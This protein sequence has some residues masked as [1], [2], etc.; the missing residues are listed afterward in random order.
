MNIGY[1]IVSVLLQY[2][3]G[4]LI[5]HVPEIRE[6]VSAGAGPAIRDAVEPFLAYIEDTGLHALQEAYTRTFDLGTETTLYMT[7]HL[8][9][10][11]AD[12]GMALSDLNRRYRASGYENFTS[13]LPDFLPL[14][15]EF[16]SVCDVRE[17][18]MLLARF[19]DGFSKLAVR[20]K[21]EASPYETLISLI[22]AVERPLESAGERR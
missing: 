7:Y 1:K 5:E 6:S 13:E 12:R 9:G 16:F 15:L 8:Y 17:R 22:C 3:T 20:L 19:E 2:P 10:D 14:M 4:E 18:M 21:E 11:H